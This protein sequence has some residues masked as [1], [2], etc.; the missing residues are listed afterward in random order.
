MGLVNFEW[1]ECI[2]CHRKFKRSTKPRTRGRGLP[3]GV[4]GYQCKTC[5]PKCS[6]SRVYYKKNETQTNN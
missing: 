2:V 5:S 4:R 3:N 6:R 1:W